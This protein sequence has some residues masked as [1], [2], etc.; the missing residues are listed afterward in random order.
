MP[1]AEDTL[2][3]AFALMRA[4]R[5]A[6]AAGACRRVLAREPGDFGAR[7]LLGVAL[8]MQGD[9][10]SAE[11]E[12]AAAIAAN[13]DVP[14][15]YYNRGN[16]L[17]ALDRLEEAVDS[18]DA[19]LARAPSMAEAMHNRANALA[20]LGRIED[21][22]AGYRS[23]IA[24]RTSLL[25]AHLALGEA[26]LHAGRSDEALPCFESVLSAAPRDAAALNG[27]GTA[28]YRQGRLG[29]ALQAYE[30]AI[31]AAP[32]APEPH[33]N[34]GLVLQDLGR[35]RDAIAMHDRALALDPRS[36]AACLHRAMARRELGEFDQAL[37]DADRALALEP[38]SARAL[39]GR[40]I[41]LNDLGRYEEALADYDAAI[42]ADPAFADA[43]NNRG[44]VLYDMGRHAE[45]LEALDRALE[46]K[47]AFP[48]AMS[49]RGL[50]LN[51]TRRFDAALQ[52]YDAAIALRPDS[53]ET[54]KRRANLHLLLGDYAQGWR[55]LGTS[56]R[57][58]RARRTDALAHIPYW[59]GEPLAGRRILL[60]EPSGLGDTIQFWRFVPALLALGA[61]VA[62]QGPARMVRL[63]SS[64]GWPVRFL[65]RPDPHER[66]DFRS[67]LWSLPCVLDARLDALPANVPYLHADEQA[68]ARTAHLAQAG[69][70]NIGISWQGN[71]ARKIDAGRSIPLAAFR[72]LSQVPGV[73]LVSLQRNAGVEQLRGAGAELGIVDP[74]EDFDAGGDAFLDTAALMTR[75]DL[76][77]SS[78]TATAHLA[79]ALGRP[80]WVALKWIP[81]WRWLLDRADSPWYPTAR[82]F[83]QREA[84][85]WD[86]VFAGMAEALQARLEG[87]H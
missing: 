51:D 41:V 47:P 5:P 70:F 68:L 40:A 15:A 19:A 23:A 8:L 16:A 42:A 1:P 21:A 28:L 71:P 75:L 80:V 84:G 31:A 46:L 35:F 9:A 22:I 38:G 55:D 27:R 87:R 83:R 29:E 30:R 67:E 81:D 48:E 12:I 20:G 56:L 7:H 69:C 17:L 25:E 65:E 39:N 82:L 33:D 58:A 2:D 78:D 4:G 3:A 49:N 37:R 74:G 62:F 52:A 64:S 43:H 63:L 77:V 11:R 45:A 86:S 13:P 61:E 10:A 36:G 14:G 76:V 60:S 79:G 26:L 34:R 24:A 18:F 54:F 6:Q 57:H 32:D 66:F 50:V 72:A 44:N 85:D 73:R 59:E 53:A